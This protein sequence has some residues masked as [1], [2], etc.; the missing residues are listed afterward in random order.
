MKHLIKELI[1]LVGLYFLTFVSVS[2]AQE[3][4]F[5]QKAEAQSSQLRDGFWI[6][7][8]LGGG[9]SSSKEPFGNFGGR[10]AGFY[11]RAGGTVNEHVL[12]GGEALLWFRAG[13]G[14]S[15]QRGN[16]TATVLIYPKSDA[17]YFF[18]G[19]FGIASINVTSFHREGVGTTFGAGIHLRIGKNV[20]VT[21]NADVLIQF[22]E[23]STD[24]VLLF[25]LGF[26]WH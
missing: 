17:E 24:A 6:G 10:G 19:G 5:Q 18:K 22:F 9:W 20:S 16:V 23:N 8:G 21:P 26:T 4:S 15:R 25:T 2:H 12:F 7:F 13:S 14:P 11:F 3:V 1:V